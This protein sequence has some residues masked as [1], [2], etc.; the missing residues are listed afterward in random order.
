[1]RRRDMLQ[2]WYSMANVVQN[3]KIEFTIFTENIKDF[4]LQLQF[5]FQF[6]LLNNTNLKNL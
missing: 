4:K 1:M 5:E 3:T 6:T 2:R